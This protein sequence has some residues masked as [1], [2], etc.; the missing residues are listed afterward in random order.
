MKYSIAGVECDEDALYRDL[1]EA[2]AVVC[3]C[4]RRF[5]PRLDLLAGVGAGFIERLAKCQHRRQLGTGHAVSA[6]D[7]AAK[8]ALILAAGD[9]KDLSVLVLRSRVHKRCDY[10]CL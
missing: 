1:S 4:F 7:L 5:N 9:S 6:V 10:F 3:A 2:Y 8:Q